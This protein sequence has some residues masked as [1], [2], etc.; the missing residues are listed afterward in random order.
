MREIIF[1]TETTGMDPAEGDRLVEIGCI[2]VLNQLPTGRTYHQY[3]NPERDIPAGAIAVH[4]ITNEFVADKPTFSQIFDEFL[5]FIGTDSKLV[6]HNAEFDMK[7]LNA[8]LKMVGFPS[9]DRKR[10]IDSLKIARRKF[11][12]A[13]AS[14]D[15]LCRR[16]DIDL[17]S[18]E[19]HGALLDAQLLADVYLELRGGRQPGLALAGDRSGEFDD[20]VRIERP[21]RAPRPHAASPEDLARHR[22]FLETKVKKA[23]WLADETAEPEPA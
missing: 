19:L 4:G 8:E 14:L 17:S 7:F 9:I 13:P 15:A 3:V 16:F 11:P 18:R 20:Y 10:V 1:D 6:A 23:L 21:Y 12:G 22:A 5:E 2:E